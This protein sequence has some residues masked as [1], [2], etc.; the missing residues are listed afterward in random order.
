M[1]LVGKRN[2]QLQKPYPDL[3]F[4]HLPILQGH[5]VCMHKDKWTFTSSCF[6]SVRMLVKTRCGFDTVMYQVL[7]LALVMLI[8]PVKCKRYRL[9]TLTVTL[10]KRERID[11]I[12]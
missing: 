12:I 1:Y 9:L 2:V 10:H 4:I 8:T 6:L 7:L 3:T 11:I 5:V